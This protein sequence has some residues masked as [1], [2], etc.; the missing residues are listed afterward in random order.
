MKILWLTNIPSP[1]RVDFFNELGK[2]C[3]LTVLFE[4]SESSERDNS[5][6]KYK[7][8]SFNGV[9]LN[10]FNIG[11]DTAISFK[12]LK[13]LKRDRYDH[14]VISNPLT[15]T[16]IIS[17]EYLRM[18]KIPYS[19]VSDGG[20]PKSGKGIKEKFKRHIFKGANI[21]FS[22]ANI[23]DQYYLMYG[24]QSEKIVR[25]PFTSLKSTDILPSP[26]RQPEKEK[27]RKTLGMIEEKIVISVGRFIYSKGYDI[28]LN[29]SNLLG[30]N[31]GVYIIGGTPTEE[32]LQLKSKLGLS[33]VHFE[34]FKTKKVLS[35]YLSAADLFVLPTRGDVWGLVINESM[36]H[37]LPVITTEQCVAGTELVKDSINGFIIPIN[38]E[39]ILA[40]RI[41]LVLENDFILKKMSGKSLEKIRE[42]TIEN[43]AY[44]TIEIFKE[45][46]DKGK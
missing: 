3:E 26:L 30:K 18:K 41:K 33:N 5:W 43:M 32:Y 8:I 7:F 27:V 17:I 46:L 31:I 13:F 23:H 35:K 39:E 28:L 2:Y 42:Y 11:V 44:I 37:G 12:I 15:P 36:A 1:Y 10:G 38:D 21:Y 22:T 9:I 20:S 16:G 19:I 14:I 25:Y 6:S 24:A 40:N 45:K 34:G 4:R 29:A